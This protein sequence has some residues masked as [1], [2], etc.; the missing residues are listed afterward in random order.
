MSSIKRLPRPLLSS[1]EW[2]TEGACRTTD[3]DEFFP[4]EA[5][6]GNRRLGREQRAKALCAT[7]PVIQQ[8]FE[9]AMSVR[10]PYGV[11]GGTTPEER[12]AMQRGVAV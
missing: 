6:R 8:C 11:W 4:H 9:H 1:Y 2:Q 10:E 3:P 12:L 5:E 7:C